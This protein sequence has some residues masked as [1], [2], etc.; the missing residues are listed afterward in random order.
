MNEEEFKESME[1]IRHTLDDIKNKNENKYL[2]AVSNLYQEYVSQNK[3]HNAIVDLIEKLDN[4]CKEL[5]KENERLRNDI[6]NMYDEEVVIN[7]MCDEF[8]L[9]RS[10]ALELL[11]GE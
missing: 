1:Y 8:N 3:E 5:L 4:M 7:V 6:S 11:R 2:S 10:E 9:S